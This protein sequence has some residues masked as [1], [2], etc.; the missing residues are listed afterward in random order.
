MGPVCAGVAAEDSGTTGCKYSV[1][2]G[3]RQAQVKFCCGH[4]CTQDPCCCLDND[5]Q[6][7]QEVLFPT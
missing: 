2:Q 6:P 4:P 3:S 1:V 5:P 7:A